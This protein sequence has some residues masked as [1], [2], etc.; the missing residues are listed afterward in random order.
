MIKLN[1]VLI[2]QETFGDGTLKCEEPSFMRWDEDD[3]SFEI[4][5]CYDSDSELFTLIV[6]RDFLREN[7]PNSKVRLKMPYIPH[8]RQDRCVSGRLFTLK[9]FAKVINSLDF[10]RVEVWDP[11]S[12][13]SKALIDRIYVEPFQYVPTDI[14]SIMMYPDNGAAKKYGEYYGCINP[15]IGNKHRNK[16][17]R[18]D[19]YELLNFVEGTKSVT[20]RD[21]ICSYG[22]TFSAA[23][24]ALRERGVEHIELIV[25]HCE[26]NILKGDVLNYV[27]KVI[28][29]DSIFTGK[30]PKIEVVT[31][32]RE[33]TKEEEYHI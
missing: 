32:F 17:G 8:A 29:T 23:A 30:H 20:I 28:T 16:E 7:F 18:I 26:N 24:K 12:D 10:Y 2:R 33:I 11:H 25:T 13:V 5:W 3:R 27:D 1:D 19:S 15:I 22:G 21:D 31:H 6:L 9:S 4:L 14:H